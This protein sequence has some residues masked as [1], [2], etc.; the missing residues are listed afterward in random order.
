[1]QACMTYTLSP[2]SEQSCVAEACWS[3]GQLQTIVAIVTY[4]VAR[5]EVTHLGQLHLV[6][7]HEQLNSSLPN[8]QGRH[9]GQEVIAHK[10][11]HEHCRRQVIPISI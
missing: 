11:A 5:C 1:M 8:L 9:V 10:E 4:L 7:M 3:G 2:I 6:D